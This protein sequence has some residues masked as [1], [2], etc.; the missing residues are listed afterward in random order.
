MVN[1]CTIIDEVM[2]GLTLIANTDILRKAPPANK[3]NKPKRLLFPPNNCSKALAFH[4][5]GTG[6]KVPTRKMPNKT[7]VQMI[8]FRK[9]GSLKAVRIASSN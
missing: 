5:P 2:Y 6:I 9:S 4:G 1:N 3:S 8:F 7:K